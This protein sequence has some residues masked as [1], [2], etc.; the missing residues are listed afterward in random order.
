MV[1]GHE[2]LVD[3]FKELTVNSENVK[4]LANLYVDNQLTKLLRKQSVKGLIAAKTKALREQFRE[5]TS[6]DA[7][8]QNTH[9]FRMGGK[10]APCRKTFNVQSDNQ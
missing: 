3:R 7:C 8:M 9:P 2:A 1:R 5:N 6:L 4:E 10:R